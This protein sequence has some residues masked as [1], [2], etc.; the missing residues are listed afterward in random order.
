VSDDLAGE[1]DERDAVVVA[2]DP[3]AGLEYVDDELL[4]HVPVVARVRQLVVANASRTVQQDHEIHRTVR[5]TNETTLLYSTITTQAATQKL[6]SD[7]DNDLKCQCCCQTK[8]YLHDVISSHL[9][10]LLIV[11]CF[12]FFNYSIL[13][14]ACAY[15]IRFN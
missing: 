9:L 8:F 12:V 5:C 14:Y 10:A 6:T 1:L 13:L 3:R 2:S 7:N 4:G 15:V 11:I